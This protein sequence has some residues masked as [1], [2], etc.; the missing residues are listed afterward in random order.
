MKVKVSI[1]LEVEI[2]YQQ[3]I[4]VLKSTAIN[5][6]ERS[7]YGLTY[8]DI[9]KKV[10]SNEVLLERLTEEEHEFVGAIVK[11]VQAQEN[12]EKSLVF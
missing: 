4:D 10:Y 8:S 7:W 12:Y 9:D 6:T 5:I 1:P 2:S 3:A 11:L